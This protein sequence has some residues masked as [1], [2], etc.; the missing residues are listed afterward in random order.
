MNNGPV[1]V[2]DPYKRRMVDRG[3]A[4]P[5]FLIHVT[6]IAEVIPR[7]IGSACLLWHEPQDSDTIT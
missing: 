6:P 2:W 4:P 3:F 1:P 5:L 7:A